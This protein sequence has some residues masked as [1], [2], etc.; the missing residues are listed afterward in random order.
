MLRHHIYVFIF[1]LS[2]FHQV[3]FRDQY[4]FERAF[5]NKERLK[6]KQKK[7]KT[8]QKTKQNKTKQNKT[9]N[10]KNN[11]NNNNNKGNLFARCRR[12]D[13]KAS[14]FCFMA[15]SKRGQVIQQ[16]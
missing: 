3:L 4:C 2:L 13:N 5:Q 11:N 8:K 10:Q 7:T 14:V 12:E 1:V 16:M 6:T 15:W 9:K